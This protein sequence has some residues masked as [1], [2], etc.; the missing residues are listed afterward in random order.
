VVGQQPFLKPGESFEY[1]SW[2]SIPTPDGKMKGSYF[3][4]SEEAEFFS[5]PIPEFTLMMPRILH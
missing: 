3:C 4:V 1:T 2:A 5:A